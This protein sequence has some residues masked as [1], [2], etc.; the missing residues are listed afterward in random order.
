MYKAILVGLNIPGKIKSNLDEL[1]ELAFALSIQTVEKIEQNA[2]TISPKYFIG[3]GKV[4]EIK[5]TIDIRDATLVIFDDTLSPAQLSHLEETLAVQVMDRS[6]LILSIFAERAQTKEAVLE[7]SLAQKLYMLP[8][9]K[10]MGN[11]LSRQGGGYG[12]RKGRHHRP[13]DLRYPG[14]HRHFLDL[15]A[16]SRREPWGSGHARQR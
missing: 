4:E 3:S 11:V 5:K 15:S 9:L 12:H 1:E 2:K 10:G 6:F 14:Q 8:R 13:Q 7:V 16:R